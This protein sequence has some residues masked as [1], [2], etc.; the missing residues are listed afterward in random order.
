MDAATLL[1]EARLRAGLSQAQL[2][3]RSGTS[4][5]TLCAYERG[6]KTPSAST[7]ER[8]LAAAGRRLTTAPASRPVRTPAAGALERAGR[9]LVEVLELAAQLPSSHDRDE[10]FPGLPRTG[11]LS[12]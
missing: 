3:E 9:T 6:T 4:Q 7:L 2:A 10:L 5:A 1:R 11:S 8:V 12:R